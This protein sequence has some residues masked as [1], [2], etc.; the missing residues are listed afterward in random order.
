MP[1]GMKLE[2]KSKGSIRM[3]KAGEVGRMERNKAKGMKE[4]EGKAGR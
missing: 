2:L 3:N 4:R 1:E